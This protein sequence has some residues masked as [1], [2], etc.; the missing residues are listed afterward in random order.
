MLF[1]LFLKESE[2]AKRDVRAYIE[3]PLTCLIEGISS[4]LTLAD[5]WL[6]TSKNAKDVDVP[7]WFK[8]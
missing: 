5:L 6:E 4:K 7:I 2:K 1:L 3:T 8:A